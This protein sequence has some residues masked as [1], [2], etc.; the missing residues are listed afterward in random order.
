MNIWFV[1]LQIAE[2]TF[3]ICMSLEMSLKVMA[4]GLFFTPQAVVRDIGGILD[5][6]IYAVGLRF[7]HFNSILNNR[8]VIFE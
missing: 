7:L 2:Y 6:F 3:V 5:V 1:F 4:N 8:S